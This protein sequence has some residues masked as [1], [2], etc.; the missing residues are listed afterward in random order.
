MLER[1]CTTFFFL[2]LLPHGCAAAGSLPPVQLKHKATGQS[3]EVLAVYEAWF[4]HPSHIKIDYESNNPAVIKKQ[5][6]AA[7]AMGISGFVVDWYGDREPFIDESYARMQAIAGKQK[8]HVAM[9]YDETEAEDGA[10]DE[11]IA[12][13]TTFHDTYLS[14]KAAGRDA[15]LTYNGR[16]VIFIFPTGEH[17]NWDKVR[18]AVNKWET[19]PILIDENLPGKYAGAFDGYYAW[20]NPGP[21][22]WKSD[23]SNWGAGYLSNFYETMRAKYADKIIVGGAWSQFNDSKASWSLNRHMDARCGQTFQDTSNDW[24]NYFTG[25]NVIPFMLIAT[26]NDY[27]E[28][29]AIERGIP[30]CANGVQTDPNQMIG[31]RSTH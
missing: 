13:F 25:E 26:W 20:V 27:E 19:P 24:K 14:A 15:Y 12:D 2:S 8:F 11:A 30:T 31:S 6:H 28:G 17:T 22:G 5:I 10:T 4:G 23:G 18:A 3:P 29:T 7:K 16:P 9:M 21:Q 1:L